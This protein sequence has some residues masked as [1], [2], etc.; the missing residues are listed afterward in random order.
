[1]VMSANVAYSSLTTDPM[2]VSVW[3]LSC[4]SLDFAYVYWECKTKCASREIHVNFTLKNSSE[5]HV[6]KPSNVN[7]HEKFPC[8]L[9]MNFK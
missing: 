9:Y 2:F 4:T 3:D 7:S 8:E 1:V 5:F 6:K